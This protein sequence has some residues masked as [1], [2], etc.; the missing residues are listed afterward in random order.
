MSGPSW[1]VRAAQAKKLS[2]RETE[3]M[4]ARANGI[5]VKAIGESLGISPFTV[6]SHLRRVFVKLHVHSIQAAVFTLLATF[7]QTRDAR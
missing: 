5:P 4:L 3:I 1:F 7:I 2:P 6:D